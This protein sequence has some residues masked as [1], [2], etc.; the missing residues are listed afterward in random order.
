MPARLFREAASSLITKQ[1]VPSDASTQRSEQAT[2]FWG[3]GDQG[4]F[5]GKEQIEI[6]ELLTLLCIS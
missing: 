6:G 4:N 2:T 3:V 1:S 5:G